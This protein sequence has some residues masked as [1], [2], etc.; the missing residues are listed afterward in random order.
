MSGL[1]NYLEDKLLDHALRNTAYTPAT[2]V[3]LTLFVGSPTDA[4]TGGTEVNI[5][6]QAVTFGASSSG[7]VSNSASVSFASMPAVTVTHIAVYDH[8]SAGNLLFHGALSSNVVAASGDTFTIQ[9]NDLDI[10]LD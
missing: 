9:A 3:Y 4:G 2:A 6:R 7:T 8:E 1:A 10:T 5:T